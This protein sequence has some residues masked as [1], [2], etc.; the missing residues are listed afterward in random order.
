MIKYPHPKF[1]KSRVNWHFNWMINQPSW[2]NADDWSVAL[3]QLMNTDF[4]NYQGWEIL[5]N[6]HL[7]SPRK[8]RIFL[9]HSYICN[10]VESTEAVV[11]ESVV[12][13]RK[14]LQMNPTGH[15]EIIRH[16]TKLADAITVSSRIYICISSFLT[17]TIVL[18]A[19][20][21]WNTQVNSWINFMHI[22]E[23]T[24]VVDEPKVKSRP[25]VASIVLLEDLK[26]NYCLFLTVLFR[27]M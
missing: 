15:K 27:C 1:R 26:K 7:L 8:C 22:S 16:M 2:N 5:I 13:I 3:E 18:L 23:S 10:V 9:W 12:V 21:V 11:A 25:Y 4:Q 20:K 14:L 19:C 17:M 6:V 24:I